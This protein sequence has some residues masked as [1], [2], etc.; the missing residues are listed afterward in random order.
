ELRRWNDND[1]RGQTKIRPGQALQVVAQAVKGNREARRSAPASTAP[2]LHHRVKR[3]DTL[4]AI[5]RVH[6]VTPEELR[7]WNDLGRQAKLRTGQD[8]MIRLSE[9]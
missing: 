2:A 9:S 6:D 8:L 3:G 4:W 5:A 7:R 1:L